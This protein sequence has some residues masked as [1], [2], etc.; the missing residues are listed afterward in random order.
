MEKPNNQARQILKLFKSRA[1]V[2]QVAGGI[3]RSTVDSWA[4]RDVIPEMMKLR[5]LENCEAYDVSKTELF[6]IMIAPYL[7]ALRHDK[8]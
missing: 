7:E 6:G 5:L 1:V 8:R 4:V 3:S 2:T